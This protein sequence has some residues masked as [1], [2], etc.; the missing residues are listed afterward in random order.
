MSA[1]GE[2]RVPARPLQHLGLHRQGDG[3][4]GAR[5]AQRRRPLAV[6]RNLGAVPALEE[7][8]DVRAPFTVQ[9]GGVLEE[10]G[11]V[12]GEEQPPPVVGEDVWDALRARR[13]FPAGAGGQ[14]PRKVRAPARSSRR[15]ALRDV[16][17]ASAAASTA[18]SMGT[19]TRARRMGRRD[20]SCMG[21]LRAALVWCRRATDKK[22]RLAKVVP[23]L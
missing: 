9:A 16:C 7:G 1:S 2:G 12:I 17:A 15:V 5:D 4:E 22:A 21:G 8:V 18:S 3:E 6:H 10:R 20:G 14:R 11:L 19:G 13:R 23:T